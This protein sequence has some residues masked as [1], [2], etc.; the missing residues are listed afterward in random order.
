MIIII[1]IFVSHTFTADFDLTS[2][3]FSHSH[4]HW[5]I[6]VVICSEGFVCGSCSLTSWC[7]I[8]LFLLLGVVCT[9]SIASMAIIVQV[10]MVMIM[11]MMVMVMVMVE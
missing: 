7:I 5:G 10:T 4:E 9:A 1:K 3:R 11:V 2:A 6:G 8:Y